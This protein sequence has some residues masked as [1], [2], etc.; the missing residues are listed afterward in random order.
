M[1]AETKSTSEKTCADG[2][3]GKASETA[4]AVGESSCGTMPR[5]I[6]Q[7]ERQCQDGGRAQL[8][9]ERADE[10]AERSDRRACGRERRDQER[11]AKPRLAAAG[12]LERDRDAEGDREQAAEDDAG[13]RGQQDLLDDQL[14]RA[15]KPAREPPDHVL[16]AL[17]AIAPAASSTPT[18]QS[19]TAS[20]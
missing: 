5:K 14:G 13:E 8:A 9:C 7:H 6:I 4:A 2:A 20:A 12:S 19:E 15:R 11:K 18:K 16:V 1:G 17:S 10:H 3:N